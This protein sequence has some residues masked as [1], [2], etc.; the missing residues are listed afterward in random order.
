VTLIANVAVQLVQR[1][2]LYRVARGHTN[3]WLS[4]TPP[5]G[6]CVRHLAI[7]H[8]R[9]C[10]HRVH[11]LAACP[12]LSCLDE[13]RGKKVKPA[14]YSG[15]QLLLVRLRV[16]APTLQ[17]RAA[18]FSIMLYRL[19]DLLGLVQSCTVQFVPL[20]LLFLLFF[21]G[22]QLSFQWNFALMSRA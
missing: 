4:D 10:C 11:S 6:P 1:A 22:R 17:M 8:L 20:R 14:S 21:C 18:R 13:P 12:E 5:S 19:P 15:F 9:R 7:V 2:V 16:R 3:S